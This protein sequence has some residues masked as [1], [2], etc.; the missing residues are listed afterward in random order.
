MRI[1][2]DNAVDFIQTRKK[3]R[4]ILLIL[5]IPIIFT[6]FPLKH[7]DAE[8]VAQSGKVDLSHWSIA[9]ELIDLKGEWEFYWEQLLD[10]VDFQN[11]SNPAAEYVEVPELWASYE[12]NN[13]FLPSQGYATYRLT[14]LL[15]DEQVEQQST[16]GLYFKR[17][18]TS[19]RV[20][21]NGI[22][23]GGNG[24]VGKTP[25]TTTP[26]NYPQ[27]IYFEAQ[28]GE[29][30]L[31]IQVANFVHNHGGMWERL[32][33]GAANLVT[34]KRTVNVILQ[35]FVNGLFLMMATYFILIYLFRKKEKSSLIFGLMC[36][37][38][39]IRVIV[40]SEST[41][42]YLFQSLP[43]EWVAK[44]EYISV[45]LA[46]I[47]LLLFIHYEYPKEA[48]RK[49]PIIISVSLSLFIIFVLCTPA[50]IFTN[51]IFIFTTFML[52]PAILYTL[53]VYAMSAIYKRKGSV[54]NAVGF[55]FFFLFALNDI[56]FYNDI[57]QTGD[58]LSY[59]LLFF[60]FTQSVNLSSRFSKALSEAEQL[61]EQLK[62]ANEHLEIKVEER[63][64]K[65]KQ[66]EM[67]RTQLLTNISHELGTPIT[68]IKGYS[69][70]LRDGII[71]K[72]ATKY[73]DRIY[74]RTI[75]LERLIDDLVEL[76]KLET[77]QTQFQFEEIEALPFF[78]HLFEKYEW[79]V[80]DKGFHLLFEKRNNL[81]ANTQAFMKVDPFRIEQVFS[82][83]LT[84]ALKFSPT[85]ETIRFVLEWK[86][87]KAT[88]GQVV[89]HII[90]QGIGIDPAE[91][92]LIFQRFHQVKKN[93]GS[94]LGLAIC[95][96]IIDYHD[97][98]LSV[99][100][101]LNKGSD[102]YFTL[103]IEFVDLNSE[104]A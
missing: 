45:S 63:T 36:F 17:I 20:W 21:V 23:K 7:A 87:S 61:S 70:A 55:A 26:R 48:I 22:E 64:I 52:L 44:A 4:I 81:P 2:E 73:A 6:L 29:N 98:E 77:R 76:T 101:Q 10:P 78:T 54:S 56:L 53:Y 93:R 66:M 85:G 88:V 25:E 82:N 31:I 39:S 8:T 28:P 67:F 91:H 34:Y 103:P 50:I 12:F 102:F 79:E 96:E 51:Y 86:K 18:E 62:E 80:L 65:L 83:L 30:E 42:L 99:V 46:A 15:S 74:E 59:G 3:T 69:K 72:D 14:F 37:F 58:Y 43:W 95:K 100:S 9:N 90:D 68:S 24:V 32:D 33:L 5:S 41:A 71:T 92:E 49:I 19:Y 38:I 57:I 75:L 40:L 47:M 11:S 89:L 35:S 84:N 94:G 1:S 13:Q 27:V 60:L 104:G 16:L 97:G